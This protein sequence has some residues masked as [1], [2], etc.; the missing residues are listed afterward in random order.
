MNI[1]FENAVKRYSKIIL[2]ELK[3]NDIIC[4][5]AGGALR[6]YFSGVPVKTDIDIFFPSEAE[7][8]KC[9]M[10]LLKN[11]GKVIWESDNGMKVIYNEREFDLVK[12]WF[13][14]PQSTIND[15]DFTVSM[16]AIDCERVYCGETTFIDLAKR[17]LMLNKLQFP[18]NTMRRAF[19]Y[20]KKGF[21]MCVGEMEKLVLAI[22]EMPK[23][24]KEEEQENQNQT[25]APISNSGG[26]RGFFVGID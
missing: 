18:A 16:L 14:D 10:Y 12:F 23:P 24:E 4:W 9:S 22:Q 15:F 17:Q 8:K 25:D 5:I 6:D 20:Y 11:G 7:H 2:S 13:P 1:Q 21:S 26:R 3:E 19:K